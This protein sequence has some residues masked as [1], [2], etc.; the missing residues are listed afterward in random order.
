MS[1][2]K[3]ALISVLL[4][5]LS[6]CGS[7]N[8]SVGPN[9]VPETPEPPE[10]ISAISDLRGTADEDLSADR[11][12]VRLHEAQTDPTKDD[13]DFYLSA[14]SVT[15]IDD[16]DELI[17]TGMPF[18]GAD[19]SYVRLATTQNPTGTTGPTGDFYVYRN[20]DNTAPDEFGGGPIVQFKNLAVHQTS[21]NGKA[22]V[23]V[24]A[25]TAHDEAKY[26]LSAFIYGRNGGVTMPTTNQADFRGD[27][28]AIRTFDN[29]PKTE[30]VSG[31]MLLEIDFEKLNSAGAI[32]FNIS[33]RKAYSDQGEFLGD[34]YDVGGIAANG[35]LD[36]QGEF[37]A[38][39]T[40]GARRAVQW[41]VGADGNPSEFVD[42]G[43]GDGGSGTIQGMLVGSDADMLAVDTLE[44]TGGDDIY[45]KPVW[46]DINEDGI[47]QVTLPDELDRTV[48]VDRFDSP[49]DASVLIESENIASNQNEIFFRTDEGYFIYENSV[50]ETG[51]FLLHRDR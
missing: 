19:D 1:T 12:I 14:N 6:A 17:I 35:V 3:I 41:V 44:F 7:N 32:R 42:I 30:Y 47:M 31:A 22:Y 26:D 20:R 4:A 40:I 5:G 9:A 25:S 39:G 28:A 43:N 18:D 46:V 11:S 37:Q 34:L 45:I 29:A 36:T 2:S 23:T 21:A 13:L 15:V 27:Y 24:V 33:E 50:N 10:V 48:V 49:V 38:E 51:A 8:K 16:G